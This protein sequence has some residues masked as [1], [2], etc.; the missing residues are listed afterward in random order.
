MRYGEPQKEPSEECLHLPPVNVSGNLGENLLP[1]G[2]VHGI[3]KVQQL[4]E[5]VPTWTRTYWALTRRVSLGQRL[6]TSTGGGG[7]SMHPTA[8]SNRFG[9]NA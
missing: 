4:S 8:G 3:G 2:A 7:S 6:P 9:L 5:H 1:S